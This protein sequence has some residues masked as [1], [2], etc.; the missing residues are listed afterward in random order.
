MLNILDVCD[1]LSNVPPEAYVKL[2]NNCARLYL[3][4]FEQEYTAACL[5]NL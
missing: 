1:T 4:R 3:I 5:P 2:L